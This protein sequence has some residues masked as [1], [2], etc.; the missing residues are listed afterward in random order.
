MK[1]FKPK[2]L[3]DV[4]G[5]P[6]W[7]D[8]NHYIR[9][10]EEKDLSIW[11]ME[12]LKRNEGFNKEYLVESTGG[13]TYKNGNPGIKLEWRNGVFTSWMPHKYLNDLKNHY[14]E[15]AGGIF[16]PDEE[17]DEHPQTI[18]E[19]YIRTTEAN[20]K[21]E[22]YMGYHNYSKTGLTYFPDKESLEKYRDNVRK[23]TRTTSSILI[24]AEMPIKKILDEVKTQISKI[25]TAKGIL[26]PRVKYH[27]FDTWAMG[28]GC[29][30]LKR[31][32]MKKSEII[33]KY[34]VYCYTGSQIPD[35]QTLTDDENNYWKDAYDQTVKMI[36]EGWKALVGNP[37]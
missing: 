5:L 26:K 25:R 28:L 8:Y 22:Y 29:F 19:S 33:K 6:E 1:I 37:T 36:E 2:N 23:L 34:L 13:I 16:I 31:K 18:F 9:L 7:F 11:A 15:E 4:K 20:P 27:K 32:G 3:S 30:D 17:K 14:F 10:S 35:S 21:K 24:N 12:F